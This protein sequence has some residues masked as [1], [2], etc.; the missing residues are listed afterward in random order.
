MVRL[1]DRPHMTLDV[2]RGRKTTIQQHIWWKFCFLSIS[3]TLML[4]GKKMKKK[5]VQNWFENLRQ[6]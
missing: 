5:L 3:R 4:I 6:P 1:T 2:Y